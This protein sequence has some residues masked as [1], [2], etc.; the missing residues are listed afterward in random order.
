MLPVIAGITENSIFLL[1]ILYAILT[2]CLY[3][4]TADT[5]LQVP[6]LSYQNKHTEPNKR[7]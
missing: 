4:N 3:Y 2:C 5:E 7:F 6:A 1:Y